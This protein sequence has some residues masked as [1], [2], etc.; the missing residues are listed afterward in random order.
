MVN[1][2]EG[3]LDDF[4]TD[5]NEIL[6]LPEVSTSEID[7]KILTS[8]IAVI[9]RQGDNL[10]VYVINGNPFDKPDYGELVDGI[11]HPSGQEI[12][13]LPDKEGYFEEDGFYGI[14][15]PLNIKDLT[16]GKLEI[17]LDDP[18]K[19]S[20]KPHNL[21]LNE[22]IL[23]S[24]IYGSGFIDFMEELKEKGI[25]GVYIEIPKE[26]EEGYT[27]GFCLVKRY[28]VSL[29]NFTQPF[30]LNPSEESL[31]YAFRE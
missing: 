12:S 28:N 1:I 7:R 8:T 22:R 17:Y 27:A 9:N 4:I 14:A 3:T 6:T 19:L 2:K 24:A 20:R 29:L 10:L 15:V 16:E 26:P 11:Y 25:E 5:F 13:K 18:R 23:A 31:Y 30:T 21:G